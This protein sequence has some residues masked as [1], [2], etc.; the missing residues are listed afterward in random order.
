MRAERARASV[1]ETAARSRKRGLSMPDEVEGEPPGAGALRQRGH[2][3]C[4]P[5][6][7]RLLSLGDAGG[8][9]AGTDD[10]GGDENALSLIHI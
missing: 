3:T 9:M 10:V 6:A 4:S 7:P 5:K 2:D 1:G 8:D